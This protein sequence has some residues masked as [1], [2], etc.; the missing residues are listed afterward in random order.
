MKC[1]CSRVTRRLYS[2]PWFNKVSACVN[3][4]LTSAMSVHE[5]RRESGWGLTRAVSSHNVEWLN[6][7][8]T[9][10]CVREIQNNI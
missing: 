8:A 4:R 1:D 9:A 7:G 3:T 6:D 2:G 5:W 10:E